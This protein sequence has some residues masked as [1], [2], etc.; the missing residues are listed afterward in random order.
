VDRTTD[1]RGVVAELSLREVRSL[2]A[3]KGERVPTLIE[4]LQLA[5]DRVRLLVEL[6][7]PAATSDVVRT[8]GECRC[9]DQIIYGSFH[10]QALLDAR[11]L[12]PETATLA[13]MEGVPVDHTR[14]CIE[15]KATYAGAS[16][17]SFTREFLGS[18]HRAGVGVFVYTANDPRDI[19]WLEALGVDGIISDFPERVRAPQA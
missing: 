16:I 2:D 8:V 13:L 18:L 1:G 7:D 11:R 6:V 4:A 3:G 19:G 17:E 9:G 10:H 14:F 12:A 5:R 15:A